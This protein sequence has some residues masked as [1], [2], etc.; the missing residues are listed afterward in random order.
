MGYGLK[1]PRR[2]MTLR[3]EGAEAAGFRPEGLAEADR[4]VEEF[5]ASRAFPGGVLAVG[6]DGA[7]AHLRAFGRLTYD[8]GSPAVTVD[9]IYDLASL[10]KVI[11]TTTM[12]MILVDEGKLDLQK[13]VSA[14][15]PGF[16]GGAKDKVTVWNLLTHSA[17]LDWWSPLYKDLKGKEAYLRRIEATDLAYEPGT[18]IPLQRSR[19]VPPRGG[20][21]ARGGRGAGHVLPG[22]GSS[23]RSA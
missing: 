20:S 11:V 1:I 12:A 8:P 15:L 21:R 5:V 14:F 7:L 9:T 16:H 10:T 22:G 3:T 4:V 13:P 6:K 19:R 18:Q 2:E 23:S 17:G